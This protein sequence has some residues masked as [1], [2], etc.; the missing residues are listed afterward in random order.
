MEFVLPAEAAA[1]NAR[2]LQE[3]NAY[4]EALTSSQSHPVV[5][6]TVTFFKPRGKEVAK[7]GRLRPVMQCSF[8][9]G[10]IPPGADHPTREALA[11]HL[12]RD[13]ETAL[14][15]ESPSMF[16]SKPLKGTQFES[17]MKSGSVPSSKKDDPWRKLWDD[18]TQE[19]MFK[20][21][22]YDA[23]TEEERRSRVYREELFNR[24]LYRVARKAVKTK[25]EK[26]KMARLMDA[27]RV[28]MQM[29]DEK[30]RK[31]APREVDPLAAGDDDDQETP[32]EFVQRKAR[33]IEGG[34]HPDLVFYSPQ[35]TDPTK[36]QEGISRICGLELDNDGDMWLL[37]N[38]WRVVRAPPTPLP[39]VIGTNFEALHDKGYFEI[40]YNFELKDLVD[41]LEEHMDALKES[42]AKLID[43]LYV[44]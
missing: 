24:Y 33:V 2:A 15:A 42:R 22:L 23:E 36:R 29:V 13:I 10:S 30:L 11:A 14:L 12:V 19:R 31:Q 3:V 40:P 27:E 43:E 4:V 18:D 26:R 32:T 28:A 1:V 8:E 44:V 39:L 5:A 20:M 7:G 21:S 38:V 25:S 34:F 41:F 35:L 16:S 9:L 17:L 37:E 6:R